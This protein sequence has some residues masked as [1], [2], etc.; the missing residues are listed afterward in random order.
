MWLFGKKKIRSD[1][2]LAGEYFATGNQAVFGELF[3]KHLRVVY[4]ACLFY[5]RDKATAEDVTMQVFEKLMVEL[6]KTK[7]DNFKGWLSFVVR[8]YCINYLKKQKQQRT[9]GEEVLDRVY[10]DDDLVLK[11]R[12]LIEQNEKMLEILHEVLPSLKEAQ[13]KC[14][15]A[16]Y[17]QKQSYEQIANSHNISL[18]EVKSHIQNGKRNLKLGIEEKMKHNEKR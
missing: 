4:G 1:E 2:E 18:N 10:T 14:V 7:P 17:L 11:E 16:F 3:E 12:E 13:R 6:R 9:V 5:F 15:E 8:N